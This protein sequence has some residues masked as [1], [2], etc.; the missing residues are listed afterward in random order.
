M[1]FLNKIGARHISGLK[2]DDMAANITYSLP[3]TGI[4]SA[5]YGADYSASQIAD[6]LYEVVTCGHNQR[7][8]VDA[9]TMS[10][11]ITGATLPHLNLFRLS[12][13]EAAELRELEKELEKHEKQNKL[14]KFKALPVHIRQSIVDESILK[15]FSDEYFNNNEKDFMHADRLKDLSTLQANMY[16]PISSPNFDFNFKFLPLLSDFTT[17]E[18][19]EAHA[20]VS[21]EEQIA[22]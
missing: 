18:L 16:Y 2:R 22:D 3:F 4:G 13:E 9:A 1:G 19:L 5:Y 15:D 7:H 8:V 10:N 21:L 12:Q 6:N 20:E 17:E 11:I 14:N